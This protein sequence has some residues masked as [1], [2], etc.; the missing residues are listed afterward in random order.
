VGSQ[1]VNGESRRAQSRFPRSATLTKGAETIRVAETPFLHQWQRTDWGID[2]YIR[3]A[4][5]RRQAHQGA[6]RAAASYRG[7]EDQGAGK[8]AGRAIQH[9][10]E[11]S[12]L[13]LAR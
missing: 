3:S 11:E 8:Q 1:I 7:H 2:G 4:Q 6:A 9:P 5:Q 13:I 10:S 12:R